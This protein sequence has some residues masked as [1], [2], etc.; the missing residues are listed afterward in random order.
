MDVHVGQKRGKYDNGW[1]TVR[2][3]LGAPAYRTMAH[4]GGHRRTNGSRGIGCVSERDTED[5]AEQPDA[6]E[7]PVALLLRSVLISADTTGEG[8]LPLERWG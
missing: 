8:E 1:R 7:P 5:L 2:D 4:R 3:G 6:I